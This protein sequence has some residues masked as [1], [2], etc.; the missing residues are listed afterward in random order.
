MSKKG[1]ILC[2]TAFIAIALLTACSSDEENDEESASADVEVNKEGFPIVDEEIEL[3]LMAPGTGI[4]EWEDMP[5]LQEYAEKTNINFTYETPPLSDFQ[6]KL[7]LAFASGDVADIIFGAGSNN[8]TP[9][10]EVD[11]GQQGVLLPLEELIADY[12]PN[13]QK[14]FE[15][16]PEVK[17]SITTSDGHI[18]SLPMVTKET[19]ASWYLGP[20]WYNGAWLEALEVDELPK[21]VDEFYDLLVR[22][23]TGDPNGNGK[24]DEIPLSDVK[25][26]SARP[27]LLGAFGIKE[28]GIEEIDGEVRY[29][30]MT[31]NYKEYLIFMNKLYEE[32]LLDSEV[33]SQSVEQKKANGQENRLGIFPDWHSYFTTGETQ[34]EALDDP[35]FHPLTSKVSSEAVIP[36]NTG[37]KRGAFSITKNNPNPEATIRWVDYF[38]SEEGGDFMRVGSE[39]HMWEWTDEG[40]GKRDYIEP[41]E[42]MSESD[43]HGG[44]TPIFGIEPPILDMPL[45]G[46]P[47]KEFDKF[48]ETE[49]ENKIEPFAEVPMPHVYLTTEE[50]DKVSSI[51]VDLQ[52]YVEQMEAKFITGVEPLS[53][54]NDYVE[55]IKNMNI[56]EYIQVYQDAYDR[57]DES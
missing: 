48:I 31:E 46:F 35:M 10:M 44:I 49:T 20:M 24:A 30:P 34:E 19:T 22:F 28:W 13:I 37:I 26:N 18:Y 11:Y 9:A 51:E 55:T 33:F 2:I 43:F 21:T 12:A 50:Q 29:A 23:K 17:K 40:A 47:E 15:E 42:G 1:L 38:Y 4:A 25:M 16:N 8:L 27:W 53:N 36:R 5:V 39:G 56:E 32:K 41:P 45:K 57:W 3:S 14:I 52:S 54:W 7:N 6:T